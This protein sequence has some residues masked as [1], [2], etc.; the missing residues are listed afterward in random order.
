M[1]RFNSQATTNYTK[2]LDAQYKAGYGTVSLSSIS[3]DHVNLAINVIPLPKLQPEVIGLNVNAKTDGAYKITLKDIVSIPQLYDV[4]LMDRYTADSVNMRQ[5]KTYSFNIT[6][7]DTNTYGSRRFSLVLRQNAAYAYK[8]VSFSAA[9]ITGAKQVKAVWTAVNE[10]NYTN[11]TVEKSTDNGKT[12]NIVGGL[13]ATGQG[14]YSLTD[15]N[16][17]GQNIYRLKQEDINGTITY[18]KP[19]TIFFTDLGNSING[20]ILSVFPN[21][22]NSNINLAINAPAAGNASFD[23]KVINSSGLVVKETTSSQASWQGNMGYLQPGIYLIRVL[24][25]K[26]DSVVGETKFIKL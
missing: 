22:V 20:N 7:S 9:K 8:L 6:R 25:S 5:N 3:N 10:G 23:I 14:T 21:P 18:S 17:S 26:T 1:F 11:F 15:N 4:W 13:A 16:P 24:N 19:V 2:D 12:F